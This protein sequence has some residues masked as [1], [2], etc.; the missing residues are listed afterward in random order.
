MMKAGDKIEAAFAGASVN[1]RKSEIMNVI[2]NLK[3][4]GTEVLDH[5]PHD[6]VP[7]SGHYLAQQLPVSGRNS[8]IEL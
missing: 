8:Q 6:S 7:G 3:G 5:A 1:D 4:P 2:N